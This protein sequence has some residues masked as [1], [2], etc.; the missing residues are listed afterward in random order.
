V[1]RALIPVGLLL[2]LVAC[3]PQGADFEVSITGT[4]NRDLTG[5]TIYYEGTPTG[6][7]LY[8]EKHGPG[9]DIQILT[10]GL[11]P[12]VTAG[13]YTITTTGQV[14][15]AYFEFID[16]VSSQFER[17]VSGTAIIHEGEGAFSGDVNFYA[18]APNSQDSVQIIG[19]FNQIPFGAQ[20]SSTGSLATPLL[21]CGFVVLLLL[22]LVLQF[23]VGSK[24]YAGE[25]GSILRS[26]RGT[27]TF[28]RG[29]QLPEIRSIMLIWS[30][31]LLLLI[32]ILGI[33][34]IMAVSINA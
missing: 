31:F 10:I 30:V 16:G 4:V 21:I 18:S 26:L 34:A 22:N 1:R 25:G 7:Q 24:V 19:T 9:G 17:N 13:T 2:F 27:R 3:S 29:W 5:A 20:G 6:R 28:I 14:S 15:A 12:Y 8:I 33:L 23:Y 32:M 11:P